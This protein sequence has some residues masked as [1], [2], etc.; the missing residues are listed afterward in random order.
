[1]SVFYT[2]ES[3]SLSFVLEHSDFEDFRFAAETD[4]KFDACVANIPYQL[5]SI[6]VSRL[7]SYMNRFPTTFK[8]AMLLVQEE[9]ALR[10]LTQP[11]NKNYSRLSA[12][13]ALVADV[14]SVVKVPREHFL[15]PPSADSVTSTTDLVASD[16]RLIEPWLQ[17]SIVNTTPK[18]VSY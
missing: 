8:C 4:K 3:W 12:N 10:L 11:G 15:P 17:S 9:F 5:S 13:A 1:M 18:P 6:V 14:T 7:S 16:A 2:S